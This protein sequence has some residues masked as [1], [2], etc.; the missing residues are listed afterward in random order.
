M[1]SRRA[2]AALLRALARKAKIALVLGVL[3]ANA[4]PTVYALLPQLVRAA[5]GCVGRV[6]L[7]LMGR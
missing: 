5:L 7:V 4:A 6:R 1:G 3:R 2:F